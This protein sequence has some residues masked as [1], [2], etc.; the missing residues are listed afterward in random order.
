MCEASCCAQGRSFADQI[1]AGQKREQVS[2]KT[3]MAV[4]YLAK[5]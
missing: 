2:A 1:L 4:F 5:A 3:D